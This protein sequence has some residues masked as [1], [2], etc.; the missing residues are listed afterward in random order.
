MFVRPHHGFGAPQFQR[1][2]PAPTPM[3]RTPETCM[4]T[5]APG[6]GDEGR[7]DPGALRVEGSGVCG[8]GHSHSPPG[9]ASIAGGKQR[10]ALP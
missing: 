5:A 10:F 1:H 4:L 8:V 6:L 9:A 2:K 7:T 3:P